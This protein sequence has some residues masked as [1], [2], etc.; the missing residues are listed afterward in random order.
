MASE[1]F[2]GAV[3]EFHGSADGL[4]VLGRAVG[5][6]VH[7]ADA[8]FLDVYVGGVHKNVPFGTRRLFAS[9]CWDREA[10]SIP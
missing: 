7:R 8:E 1:G 2:H 9:R 10:M 5:R 4:E 3:S 6:D